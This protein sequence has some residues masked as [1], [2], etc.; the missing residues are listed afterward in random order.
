MTVF[1]VKV[2]GETITDAQIGK[3]GDHEPRAGWQDRARDYWRASRRGPP[4]LDVVLTLLVAAAVGL[5]LGLAA[6][7]LVGLL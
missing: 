1:V 2:T 4:Y 5:G 7:W 3:L 6:A